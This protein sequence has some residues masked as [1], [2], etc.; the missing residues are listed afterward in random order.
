MENRPQNY[1]LGLDI[2]EL[3]AIAEKAGQPDYRARQLFEGIYAQQ[4]TGLDQFSTLPRSF[5]EELSAEDYVLGL[6]KI[7]KRFVSTDGTVRY[8][9]AFADGETVETVWM[10]E[11]DDGETGDG[12]EG[13]AAGERPPWSRATICVSSQVGCAVDCRFCLT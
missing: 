9:I 4:L 12:S 13:G 7:E 11:G 5:R 6:P 2:Q 3:R 10:P 1:L 8:L